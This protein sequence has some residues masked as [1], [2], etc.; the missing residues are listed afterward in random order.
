MRR[1]GWQRAVPGSG[2]AGAG[3]R[4]AQ[5]ASLPWRIVAR[6]PTGKAESKARSVRPGME[7]RDL[8]KW[9]GG[10]TIAGSLAATAIVAVSSQ[11]TASPSS[12]KGN[13][14]LAERQIRRIALVAAQ[15]AGDPKPTLIQ[16][17][18]GTRE[19]AIVNGHRFLPTGGHKIPHWWP[20][21]LP[22]GG[23]RISPPGLGRVLRSGASPL[24]RRSLAPAGSCLARR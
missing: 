8:R 7:R 9:L 10:I 21:F 12:H 16:H 3:K 5:R 23:H 18:E 11:A 14:R 4:L 24:C 22:A 20:S 1:F 13:P 15:G 17:S 19:K 6:R 2:V